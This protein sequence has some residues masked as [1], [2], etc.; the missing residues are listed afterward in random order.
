MADPDPANLTDEELEEIL[1]PTPEEAEPKT[2]APKEEPEVPEPEAEPEEP[3]AEPEEPEEKPVSRR[4]SLRVRELLARGKPQTPARPAATSGIDYEQ[5]LDAEPEV[6][7]QLK[8][9]RERTEQEMYNRGL[10]QTKSIQFQTRLEIDAPRIEA[11]YPQLD[12][13]SNDFHPAL[14][15]A[16]NTMYLAAVGYD[17]ENGSVQTPDLRY[18]PYVESIFELANEIA[19]DKTQE[20]VKETARQRANTGLRPDGSSA[21]RLNLNKPPEQMTDEELDAVIGQAGL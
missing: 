1:E 7:A 21:K 3:E 14:A 4:E 18:A 12:K 19:S 8:A 9:D 6:I 13:N 15:D 5:A 10:E 11:K 20:A 17:S 16:I 2:P